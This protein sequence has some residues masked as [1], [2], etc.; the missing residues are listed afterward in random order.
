MEYSNLETKNIEFLQSTVKRFAKVRMTTN[1]IKHSIFDANSEIRTY[2]SEENIHKYATQLKGQE[3][4]VF[5][6]GHIL[7]FKRSI[8]TNIS[9]YRSKTRGD[10]RMWFGAPFLSLAKER[11]IYVIIAKGA[12]L[13]VFNI[14]DIDIES[15]A[16][17]PVMNPIKNFFND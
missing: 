14:S 10:Y 9:M 1:I 15:C 4:K 12:E 7:T 2:L 5:V 11:V 13:Y 16:K 8:E 6:K 17:S 3:Y